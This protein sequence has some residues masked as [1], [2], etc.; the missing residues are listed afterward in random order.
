MPISSSPFTSFLDNRT[1]IVCWWQCAHPQGIMIDLSQR[2]PLI[3]LKVRL[4]S[5]YGQWNEGE[6]SGGFQEKSSQIKEKAAWEGLFGPLHLFLKCWDVRLC[7]LELL[8]FSGF[9]GRRQC[10]HT[11]DIAQKDWRNRVLKDIFEPLKHSG[12]IYLV[13]EVPFKCYLENVH[14][15][16]LNQ[17]ICITCYLQPRTFLN[18][19]VDNF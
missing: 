5:G 13:L 6:T 16:G 4:W 14:P 11:K 8:Q 2:W 12:I 3:D 9:F 7:N 17:F 1:Q 10:T 19:K 15:Y 18:N